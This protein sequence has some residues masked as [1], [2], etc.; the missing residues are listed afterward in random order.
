M[1][2]SKT[3][4]YKSCILKDLEDIAN[5]VR[6]NYEIFI[7]FSKYAK[8]VKVGRTYRER[9]QILIMCYY[10]NP[11][12]EELQNLTLADVVKYIE[13]T[14]EKYKKDITYLVKC[15]KLIKKLQ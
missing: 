1:L 4:D 2:G 10:V 3:E 14:D 5:G 7:D 11:T 13:D 9:L 6:R 8:L 15:V 12:L